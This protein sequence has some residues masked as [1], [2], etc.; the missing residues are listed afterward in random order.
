MQFCTNCGEKMDEDQ[1]ICSQCGNSLERQN[2]QENEKKKFYVPIDYS[3]VKDAIP[4]GNDIIYSTLFTVN[5]HTVDPQLG[6]RHGFKT[7]NYVTHALLT[8]KGIAY[9][10]LKGGV[11]KPEFIPWSKLTIFVGHSLGFQDKMT[12]YTFALTRDPDYESA[13]NLEMRLMKFYLEF[14]DHVINEKKKHNKKSL[15]HIEKAYK[16]IAE[17]LGEDLI[18]FFKTNEDYEEYQKM[19]SEKMKEMPEWAKSL[20][21]NKPKA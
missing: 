11:L 2:V 12:M 18:E 10:K 14:V 17:A 4:I 6:G 13:Q 20:V 5:T 3:D 7:N 21:I 8:E 16:K 9:Q 15:K 19:K 1:K